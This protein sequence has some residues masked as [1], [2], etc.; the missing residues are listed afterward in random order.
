MGACSRRIF[1]I[2]HL[3]LETLKET[4]PMHWSI[5]EGNF[6]DGHLEEALL[7]FTLFKG[8]LPHFAPLFGNIDRDGS[9][10]LGRFT[11]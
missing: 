2:S 11:R 7:V 4:G 1:H 5:H 6:G 3:I 10:T 9:Y 8:N